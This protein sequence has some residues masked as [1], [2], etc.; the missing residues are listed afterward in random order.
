MVTELFIKL[1]FRCSFVR[2]KKKIV[3]IIHGGDREKEVEL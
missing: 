1:Q 2:K 3:F